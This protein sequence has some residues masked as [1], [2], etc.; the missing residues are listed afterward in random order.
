MYSPEKDPLVADFREILAKV[1]G[2]SHLPVEVNIQR[3]ATMRREL[4]AR[5][6]ALK[7]K[8]T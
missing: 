4:Q 7:A 3:L 5:I 6:A 2:E 1:D 8:L